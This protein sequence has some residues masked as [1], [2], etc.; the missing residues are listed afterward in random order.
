MA[1]GDHA[2]GP[3]FSFRATR[4]R[5]LGLDRT[6][7]VDFSDDGFSIYLRHFN[8]RRDNA[9]SLLRRVKYSSVRHCEYR[10]PHVESGSTFTGFVW[11][12]MPA[13]IE[14]AIS[15][16][17][18]GPP[19]HGGGSFWNTELL[20]LSGADITETEFKGVYA[21]LRA[22]VGTDSGTP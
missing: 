4:R 20:R 11:G 21:W 22:R 12:T 3:R 5:A 8:F 9:Y 10:S 14:L 15:R 6:V 16:S 7:R 13:E 19:R 17:D 1:S 18:S 2:S